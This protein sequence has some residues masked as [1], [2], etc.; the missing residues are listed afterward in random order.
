MGSVLKEV[1]LV[2]EINLRY[3]HLNHKNDQRFIP[4]IIS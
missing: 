3:F 1:Q 2:K 4:L